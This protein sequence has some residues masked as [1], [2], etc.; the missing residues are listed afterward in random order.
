MRINV[1]YNIYIL[2]QL[3]SQKREREGE[4]EEGQDERVCEN[5]SVMRNGTS[6]IQQN[7]RLCRLSKSPFVHRAKGNGLELTSTISELVPADEH[8]G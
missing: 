8:A 4:R 1:I 3:R 7:M 6:I 5:I 2:Q